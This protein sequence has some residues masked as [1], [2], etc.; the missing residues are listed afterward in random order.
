MPG[1]FR[2]TFPAATLADALL[3]K[4]R[5]DR[6]T[7]QETVIDQARKLACSD[8]GPGNRGLFQEAYALAPTPAQLRALPEK[9]NWHI[10]RRNR[11][12]FTQY[13]VRKR[14]RGQYAGQIGVFRKKTLAGVKM[15]AGEIERR[16]ASRGYMAS[17]WL[18]AFLVKQAPGLRNIIVGNDR[19]KIQVKLGG[20]NPRITLINSTPN[21]GPYAARTGYIERAIEAR[22]IDMYAYIRRKMKESATVFNPSGRR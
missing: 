11:P 9:L 3:D 19:A 5:Y 13:E 20:T 4:N 16:I 22:I 18:N 12:V 10:R 14:K 1:Q 17:G 7:F 15:K 21:A 8:F 6:K 2:M